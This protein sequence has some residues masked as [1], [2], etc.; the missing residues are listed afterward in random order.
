MLRARNG[1]GP[2][3][4]G[5]SAGLRNAGQFSRAFCPNRDRFGQNARENWPALGSPADRPALRGPGPFL[6]QGMVRPPGK[7]AKTSRPTRRPRRWGAF[8][9]QS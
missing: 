2:R 7:R 8:P 3:R 6:A 5:Q 9:E 4:A 1:H